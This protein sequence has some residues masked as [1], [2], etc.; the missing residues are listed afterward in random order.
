M[1]TSIWSP[2]TV[3]SRGADFGR[4]SPDAAGLVGVALCSDT[5]SPAEAIVCPSRSVEL[6]KRALFLIKSRRFMLGGYNES[7]EQDFFAKSFPSND[8]IGDKSCFLLTP[9]DPD[10]GA[11]AH[12]GD[13]QADRSVLHFA[14]PSKR[15]HR[16]RDESLNDVCP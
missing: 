11:A 5:G 8:A 1:D 7:M 4:G 2:A 13:L 3:S 15:S 10:H 9:G 16:N 6:P 12:K 14:S